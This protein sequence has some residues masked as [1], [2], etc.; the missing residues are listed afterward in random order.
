MNHS[1]LKVLLLAVYTSGMLNEYEELGICQITSYLREHGYEVMLLGSNEKD[2]AYDQIACFNPDIVGVSVYSV[3]KK[4]VYRVCNRIKELLPETYICAGGSLPT[5]YGTEMLKE[6]SKFDFVIRGEGET[7]FHELL[8]ALENN[9]SLKSIKGLVFREGEQIIVNEE[10]KPV[11]DIDIFP[12]PAR[13]ILVSN[14][15]KNALISSSRGCKAKC[16]F[17]I[18]QLFWKDWRGRSIEAVV[19]EME[20]IASTYKV[21]SFTFID[22]SFE[23]PDRECKRACGI[24]EE[25]IKRK[26]EISYYAD[27]RAEFHKKANDEMMEL[28]KK[29][30]LTGVCLGLEAGNQEDL[31]LYGKIARLEDNYKAIELFAKHGIHIVPGFINF[32][33][34]STF[35]KLYENIVFLEKYGYACWINLVVSKYRTFRGTALYTKL[36]NDSLLSELGSGEETYKFV[37]H[38]IGVFHEYLSSHMVANKLDKAFSIVQ[39]YADTYM[40]FLTHLKKK[41]QAASDENAYKMV[42]NSEA[43]SK[44]LLMNIN[45]SI[46]EWYKRLLELVRSGWD[47]KAADTISD[48]VLNANY[49]NEIAENLELI[50]KQ[51]FIGLMRVDSKYS[52]FIGDAMRNY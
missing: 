1:G 21:S 32:N 16:T 28:L 46:S 12:S 36:R 30:G 7:A 4:S 20:Y 5:Y 24:A 18:S 52:S 27:F 10:R 22:S 15:L 41:I 47:K 3:S 14:K 33:P 48:N 29:S 35:E 38:R 40:V 17:C 44:A 49:V 23:D 50:K 8:C 19:D 31:K 43:Q 39:H 45:Y 51:L 37:D 9:R 25:I 26:L 13:D 11:R 34:Y 2:I 42:L 6:F